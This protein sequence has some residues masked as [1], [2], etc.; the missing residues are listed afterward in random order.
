VGFDTPQFAY[1]GPSQAGVVQVIG[2]GGTGYNTTQWSN[3]NVGFY[4]KNAGPVEAT[5]ADTGGT[6]NAGGGIITS[7]MIGSTPPTDTWDDGSG[8][9]FPS[10]I[11]FTTDTISLFVQGD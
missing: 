5:T 3:L 6:F 9:Y 8:G 1:P 7:I 4:R 10:T 2:V 11:D